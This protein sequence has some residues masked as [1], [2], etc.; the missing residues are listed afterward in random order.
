MLKPTKKTYEIGISPCPNDVFIFSAILQNRIQLS[1]PFKIFFADIELL[2]KYSLT[3]KGEVTRYRK[4]YPDFLK[5]SFATAFANEHYEPLS[6]GSAIGKGCGPLLVGMS[7]EIKTNAVTASPGKNTT[8][9]LLLRM[10]FPEL[11]KRY[12]TLFSEIPKE[13][14]RGCVAQGAIIH[15]TRFL[16]DRYELK[17][18]ADMGQLWEKKTGLPLPL[19]GI[20]AEKTVPVEIRDELNAA[21]KKS[22]KMA[23]ENLTNTI[24][25]CS[26][27]SAE[28]DTETIEKH[29]RLYVND[30]TD[31]WG[32]QGQA[33]VFK[34][35]EAFHKLTG[36]D[37]KEMS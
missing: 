5:L 4:K 1:F 34:L 27:H 15:E 12:Y 2:N 36:K 10:F 3:H 31:D 19:G 17:T 30:F 35:Q 21:L 26:H 18:I 7:E 25:L 20:F 22:I 28:K 14:K 13:I 11:K 32:S 16:C 9:D 23:W 37:D 24:S 29:I 8:A 33:A 6:T